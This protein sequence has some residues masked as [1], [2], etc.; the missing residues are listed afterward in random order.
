MRPQDVIRRKRDG[1]EL[2]HEAIA[3]FVRGV[4]QGSWADYQSSS[5][6]MAIFL[7]G[8]SEA[9]TGALTEEMLRSGETLNFSDIARPK[10]DKHSTGG[11]G[12]KTSLVLAPLAAACGVAVPMISGRGLGHTGGTLDK[13]EAIQGYRVNL[14]VAEFREVLGNVGFAMMGQTAS[15]APAD[16][17]LYALRD[18]TE[19]VEAIPL[20]VASIMSKKLAAGLDALVLDVKTGSGA[21]MKSDARARELA[22]AL[23][24]TG[25]RFGVRTE[26]L[27]TDM[28]QPLGRA[29]GNAL[30]VKECIEIL[31]G[32]AAEGAL[33]VLDLSV[34]LA[35]RM[36]ALSGVESDLESARV[37]VRRALDSGA[38]L[39][40]FRENVA[41]QGGDARVC[42]APARLFDLTLE[43]VRVQSTRAGF[44]N[45][46]EAAEVGRAVASIGG[47]R[48]RMEDSIDH[49][50]GYLCEAKIGDEVS[51]GQTLGLLYCRRAS[52]E[53]ARNAGARIVAAYRI[54]DEPP[55]FLPTLIK[56]VITE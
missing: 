53:D 33:P 15:I 40:K 55:G 10:A 49:A 47:G 56:E 5:L 50:V 31:R 48:A 25:N 13:L 30:E 12:D 3:S 11:V 24:R 14:S 4:A 20:I 17:K 9:E 16:K 21:F 35:A 45:E 34:E 39:E 32:E 8:M 41:A 29:V 18:A 2:S 52:T 22:H 46:I 54:Q 37:C 19:T 7:N 36:A 1:E 38:A 42:D 27:L 26:A 6:L 51:A 44:V 28:S 23:V 43:E